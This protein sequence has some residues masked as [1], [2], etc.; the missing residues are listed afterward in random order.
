MSPGG[1]NKQAVPASL[2]WSTLMVAGFSMYFINYT[3][4]LA[5]LPL[6]SCLLASSLQYGEKDPNVLCFLISNK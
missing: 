2:T 5:L 1:M 6:P 3:G 4:S